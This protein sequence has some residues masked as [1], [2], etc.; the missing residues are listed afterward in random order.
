MEINLLPWREEILAFNKNI[1]IRLMLGAVI[2]SAII[3]FLGYQVYFAP[4]SY[5]QSYLRALQ[6]AKTNLTAKITAFLTQK[7][8]QEEITKRINLLLS[9]QHD[10]YK[11]IRLLNEI[12]R[13]TPKGI[14]LKKMD[15]HGDKIEIDGSSNS[16]LFI[17]QFLKD[18]E[19]SSELN[20]TSLQKVE[21]DEGKNFVIT[22]FILFAKLTMEQDTVN[23]ESE[24]KN[25][26]NNP[27]T[28]ILKMRENQRKKEEDILHDKK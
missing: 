21:K 2:A 1:F 20:V 18:I 27:A 6:E 7:S 3:I 13:I 11:T 14:Y 17:A 5:T 26:I 25:E 22:Q 16:N 23:R 28:E 12:T 24:K 19:S 10:R 9:F 8:S 15:R 4:V